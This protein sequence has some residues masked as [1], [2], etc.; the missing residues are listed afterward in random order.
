MKVTRFRASSVALAAIAGLALSAGTPVLAS[1]TTAP[2]WPQPRYDAAGSGYNPA[3]TQLGTGNVG[4]LVTR[5]V[6]PLRRPFSAAAPVVADGLVIVTSYYSNGGQRGEIEAFPE[7]C[8]APQGLSCRPVWRASVSYDDSMGLT[9]DDGMVFVNT[10]T[11]KPTQKLW[12]FSLHCG[13]GDA[14]CT[15]LWTTN[16]RG[17]SYADQAPTVAG[18]VIYVPWG[19]VSSAALLA[20][21]EA[22]HYGCRPIWTGP[23]PAS[24]DDSA[25][26]ADG[27]VYVPDY[28]GSIYAFRVGCATGDK[29]CLPAWSGSVG[30]GGPRGVAIG[31]GLMFAGSQDGDL[32]AFKATGCGVPFCS[33]VWTA[34]IKPG[35]NILARPA[36]AYGMVFVTDY[37]TGD[38][39][40]FPEHC[41][42]TCKPDWWAH[43]PPEN[44]GD[45]AVANGVVYVSAGNSEKNVGIYAFS[46]HCATGGGMCTP[47][48][49][50]NGGS[51][52][53]PSGPVVAG[54]EVWATGGPIT[55]PANLYA[56]GL[57]VPGAARAATAVR[58][59]G[60]AAP[61]PALG[62]VRHDAG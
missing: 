37:V 59:G 51:Y 61:A 6:A 53:I 33:P 2:S 3:E 21:P 5:A 9:V 22:C 11:Y 4:R 39:Y 13:T 50:G 40:A 36:V 38:L 20:F 56:F 15:P 1:G 47:L 19:S 27:Y 10:L 35:A 31:G 62:T 12:V 46:V 43:L 25:A 24:I 55:G 8:G 54:G 34:V 52:Y 7:S 26:V 16:I 17:I 49:R 41:A 18:G 14:I 30:E 48:W 29:V 60:R 45:P 44:T 28:D 23:L 42:A 58:G 57:P 32:Y